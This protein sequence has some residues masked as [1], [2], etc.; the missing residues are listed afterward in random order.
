MKKNPTPSIRAPRRLS[1]G[2]ITV[3]FAA[4]L[5]V[6]VLFVSLAVDM[7][8]IYLTKAKL[9]RA[10]DATALRV[11]RKF[12]ADADRRREIALRMMQSNFPGFLEGITDDVAYWT[13]IGNVTTSGGEN[14]K[15]RAGEDYMEIQT[16]ASSAQGAITAEVIAQTTHSTFFMKLLSLLWR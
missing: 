15:V 10:A 14:Q 11:A 1:K 5:P 8:L 3:I 12:Q 16:E 4:A 7:T 2:Q 13:V 9:S 6:I